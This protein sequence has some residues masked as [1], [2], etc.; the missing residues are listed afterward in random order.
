[1]RRNL[2]GASVDLDTF[3][4]VRANLPAEVE[5]FDVD[6]I[7]IDS[8]S[9]VW[10]GEATTDPAPKYDVFVTTIADDA[11]SRNGAKQIGRSPRVA[12]FDVS[13]V[14]ER[15]KTRTFSMV[16]TGSDE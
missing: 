15:A 10:C 7:E 11:H 4:V 16:E 8:G 6:P 9:A 2:S 13:F 5:G 12:G 3:Q 1:L 14:D